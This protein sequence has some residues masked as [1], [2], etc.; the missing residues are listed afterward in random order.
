MKILTILFL[1]AS[2]L[3]SI[4]QS[5]VMK[6]LSDEYSDGFVLMFYHSTLNMLNIDDDPDFAR[7]VQDIEKIKLLRLNK[8][9]DNFTKTSLS[10]LKESLSDRGFE[11]LM[12]VKNKDMDIGVYI[13]EDDG[14]VEGFFL[15]MDEEDEFI[16]IDVLGSMPV[17]DIGQLVDKIQQA[18]DF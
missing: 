4:A 5:K 16:A 6:E 15:L 7:M 2:P 8:E 11:E 10:N 13:N 12:I 18:K 1:L 17:G 3:F 9:V 14:D